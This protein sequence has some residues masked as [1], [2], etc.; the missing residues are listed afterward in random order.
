MTVLM[1]AAPAWFLELQ[2]RLRRTYAGN[3]A[4][5]SLCLCFGSRPCEFAVVIQPPLTDTMQAVNYF[6]HCN[7]SPT[8]VAMVAIGYLEHGDEESYHYTTLCLY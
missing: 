7:Y 3:I 6:V 1:M 5:K 2:F 8:C 4:I